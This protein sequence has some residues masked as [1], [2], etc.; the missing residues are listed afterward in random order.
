MFVVFQVRRH[1]LINVPPHQRTVCILHFL[2]EVVIRRLDAPIRS[3]REHQHFAVQALSDLL[4][5]GQ[6]FTKSR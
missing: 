3:Q 5:A 2:R 6:F 4:Q 1:Q